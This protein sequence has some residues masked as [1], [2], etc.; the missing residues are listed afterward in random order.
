MKKLSMHV[1]ACFLLLPCIAAMS[2]NLFVG[3]SGACYLGL[4]YVLSYKCEPLR[5]FWKSYYKE[6]T[7]I[8]KSL[9]GK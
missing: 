2:E 9:S 1:L 7:R 8:E 4:L 6:I 3:F 5:M